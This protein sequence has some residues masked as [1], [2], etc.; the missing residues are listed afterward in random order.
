CALAP[1]AEGA[2]GMPAPAVEKLLPPSEDS[3]AV[4]ISGCCAR[5]GPSLAW[6]SL[7]SASGSSAPRSDIIASASIMLCSC[8]ACA[9]GAGP[10][11]GLRPPQSPPPPDDAG[12]EEEGGAGGLL[13]RSISLSSLSESAWL[14]SCDL[15]C[16]SFAACASLVAAVSL[17]LSIAFGSL[18]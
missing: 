14:G 5:S 8:C 9:P 12:S 10:P 15:S 7:A 13:S 1:P 11:A 17:V 18:A 16:G 6:S 4:F 3:S 2:A